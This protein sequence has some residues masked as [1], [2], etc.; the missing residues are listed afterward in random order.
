MPPFAGSAREVVLNA[1][2]GVDFEFAAVALERNREDDLTRGMR[3]DSPHSRVEFE[4]IGRFVEIGDAVSKNRDFAH[5]SG[6]RVFFS[7]QG[8]QTPK[9]TGNCAKSPLDELCGQPSLAH[10]AKQHA[11]NVLMRCSRATR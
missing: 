7:L 3:E 8:D 1:I 6:H 9:A 4:Q 11:I 5:R 2:A 10:R